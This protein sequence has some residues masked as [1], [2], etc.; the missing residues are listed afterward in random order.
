MRATTGIVKVAP[1]IVTAF[2]GM[3]ELSLDQRALDAGVLAEMVDE[4]QRG[5]AAR[6]RPRRAARSSGSRIR[7]IEPISFDAGAGRHRRAA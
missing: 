6:S 5:V 4:A 1:G 7:Q 2:N 3:C